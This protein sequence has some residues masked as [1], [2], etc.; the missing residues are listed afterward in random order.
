MSFKISKGQYA[1]KGGK[2]FSVSIFDESGKQVESFTVYGKH[3]TAKIEAE[4]RI[5]E[6]TDKE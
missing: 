3:K 4:K 1:G 2:N 5:K 6:L